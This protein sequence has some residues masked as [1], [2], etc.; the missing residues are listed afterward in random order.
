MQHFF[1]PFLIAVQFL[2]RLP[3]SFLLDKK[4][5]YTADN[6]ARSLKYY[7]L[8]GA[9]IG[10]ILIVFVILLNYFAT[11]HTAYV[12]V[13]TLF[14]WVVLS[15]GLH[16]DGVADMADAWVGGLGDKEKTL[17]I[18][19]DPTCGPFGV[20]A[21]VLALLLKLVFI[22][23]LL[24]INPLL[25]SLSPL[26]SR[27]MVVILL[28][29]TPYARSQGMGLELGV[30]TYQFINISSVIIF[31]ATSLF[32]LASLT[33]VVV[34]ISVLVISILFYILFRFNVVQRIGGV[35]GDVAGAFIEYMELIILFGLVTFSF[36]LL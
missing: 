10:L 32:W 19:K 26:L 13:L 29:F 21:I 22:Y 4:E 20:I 28:M 24:S 35:T 18:M 8:V 3:V 30:R 11:G 6:T 2:T 36:I 33:S 27:S 9:I 34:F 5:I 15:G 25:I 1:T 7:P 23:E 16:L 31:S 12:A 14:L 17:R